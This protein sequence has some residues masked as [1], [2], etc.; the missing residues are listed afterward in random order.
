MN[1]VESRCQE[2]DEAALNAGKGGHF[3]SFLLSVATANR[4]K[5]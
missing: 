3:L 2:R 4:D 5:G 1:E